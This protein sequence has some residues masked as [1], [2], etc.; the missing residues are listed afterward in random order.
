MMIHDVTALAGKKKYRKRVGRGEGSGHG[1]QAGRGHM[2]SQVL[3]R[4]S[5]IWQLTS[6]VLPTKD[7]CVSFGFLLAPSARSLKAQLAVIRAAGLS[8]Q[9]GEIVGVE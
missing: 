4:H 7:G 8:A 3:V 1:K 9:D 6:V 5:G 2:Q